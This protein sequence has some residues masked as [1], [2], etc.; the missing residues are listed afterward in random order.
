M[1]TKNQNRC[2]RQP[3]PF[4]L[5]VMLLV[6]LLLLPGCHSEIP[7]EGEP[8]DQVV[9]I[10]QGIKGTIFFWS[11]DFQCCSPTGTIT[12]VRREVHIYEPTNAQQVTRIG[13][14]YFFSSIQSKFI[15]M[16]TSNDS[17]WYQVRLEPGNY[18]IFIKEYS[19]LDGSLYYADFFPST[20][21]VTAGSITQR[22]IDITFDA[23]F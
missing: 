4:R 20:E 3:G 12:P 5:S 11:G 8:S 18:S 23:A 16:T 15:T 1:K 7:S 2:Q 19:V 21:T 22:D 6:L 14:N 9:T 17:G 10:D 13:Y